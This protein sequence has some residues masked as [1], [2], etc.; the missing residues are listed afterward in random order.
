MQILNT[1]QLKFADEYTI[2]H[3]PITSLNLMERAARAC[4]SVL[5]KK[6]DTL[7]QFVVFCGKGNNGGDG[8]A[9]ARMIIERGYGCKAVLVNYNSK[10]SEDCKINYHKLKELKSDALIEINS[11]NDLEKINFTSDSIIID[12][13]LGTGLNK[14]LSGLLEAVVQIINQNYLNVIS[15]D[16]PTGLFIDK[17]NSPEDIIIHSSHTLTFQ[18]PKLSFLFAQN[19]HFV[20]SFEVLD[21]GLH[22]HIENLLP[23]NLFFVTKKTIRQILTTRSKFSHKG[24]FG[25]ALIIAGSDTMRGA[26]S[27]G[28][29]ACLK[30]GAGLLTVHSTAAVINSLTVSLPE[31]MTSIDPHQYYITELPDLKKYDVVAIGPGVST[32]KETEDVIKKLL[33]YNSANLI[34]DADALNII[35]ENKTWLAFLPPETILTPHPKEFDR[36][37]KHHDNDFDRFKTAEQFAF[38]NK[39]ILIL[40]GAYTIICMPDGSSYFNSSGNP[41]LAKGGSGDALTGIITGLI[42]RGY[43]PAKAALIGVFV[44]GYAADISTKSSSQESLLV[45]DVI[46]A[47]GKAFKKLE[48]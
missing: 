47:L 5:T 16:C 33:N 14:P 44:H 37:T 30:S 13:L 27:I 25:H 32:N 26:A 31:A 8:F 6:A 42:A 38:N 28:A 43:T 29:K 22:P 18:Y 15:I 24:N 45:S 12:A 4:V 39:C 46:K 1:E 17:A 35:S 9:I 34:L 10:F 41:G 2:N 36:L 23:I 19:K 7:S 21:I 3:E 20:P 40:K 48:G 11:E